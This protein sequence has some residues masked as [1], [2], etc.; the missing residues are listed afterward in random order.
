MT[1]PELFALAITAP[2]TIAYIWQRNHRI[3]AE[4][5]RDRLRGQLVDTIAPSFE[6]QLD[7]RLAL[8]KAARV[9]GYDMHKR[10]G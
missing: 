2:A 5:E 6:Q 10:R 9:A 3:A 4:R 7:Q 1:N 8:R